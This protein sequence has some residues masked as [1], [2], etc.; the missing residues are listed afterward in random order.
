MCMK[1]PEKKE[2]KFVRGAMEGRSACSPK[3]TFHVKKKRK[4]LDS[5]EDA[6]DGDIEREV[7]WEALEERAK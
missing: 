1:K 7:D 5:Y 4:A 2:H 3:K 6:V